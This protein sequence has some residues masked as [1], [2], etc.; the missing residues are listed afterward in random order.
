MKLNQY[1]EEKKGVGV[2]ATSSA[3]GVVDAAVYSR[4]HVLSS[5]EVAFIMRDHL[6]HQNLQENR[7]ANYLFIEEGGGYAGV[8]LFL[9]RIDE[10]TDDKL[11]SSMSRR[12]LSPEEDRARGE[13]FL[14]RFKVDRVLNLIGGE[15]IRLD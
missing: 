13:K 3:K 1:F 5:D 8:R 4:P 2:M 11:I 15:E 14:V 10:S 9:T 6:T 7:H 12:S